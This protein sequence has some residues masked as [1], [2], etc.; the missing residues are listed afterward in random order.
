PRHPAGLYTLTHGMSDANGTHGQDRQA[1]VV[2]RDR[3]LLPSFPLDLGTS[4]ESAPQFADLNG[5]GRQEL[6][7]ADQDGRVHAFRQDGSELRGWPV[8]QLVLPNIPVKA[9]AGFVSSPAVADLGNGRP[10]VIVGGL[11]G[12][13]YA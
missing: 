2:N 11:D 10:D 9:R 13:V 4:I 8:R 7:V 6:V 3:S 1:F 12:K 5:D